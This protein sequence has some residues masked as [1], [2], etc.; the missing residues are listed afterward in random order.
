M[1]HWTAWDWITY[2]CL[3]IAAFGLALG[4][5]LKE[6]PSMVSW[7]PEIFSSP[8]WAFVPALL[9]VVATIIFLVR[10]FAPGQLDV[11]N[12]NP[13]ETKLELITGQNFKN[14]TVLLD[15]K[16]YH[17]CTFDNVTFRWNG[18]PFSIFRGTVIGHRRIEVHDQKVVDTIDM[19]QSLE[20]L[21]ATFGADWKHIPP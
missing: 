3:G 1:S 21:E 11:A 10:T 2:G 16:S 13:K 14:E 19:L 8:K 7:M 9:F 6:Y 12:Q 20:L 17:N 15:G 18:G 5:L 4:S